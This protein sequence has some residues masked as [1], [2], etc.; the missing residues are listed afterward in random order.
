MVGAGGMGCISC[1]KVI[2][3]KQEVIQSSA[4]GPCLCFI[5]WDSSLSIRG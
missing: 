2:V 1:I 4:K 3:I 5:S